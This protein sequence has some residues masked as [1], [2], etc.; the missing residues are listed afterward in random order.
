MTVTGDQVQR[1]LDRWQ[2]LLRLAD[3]DIRI[4]MGPPGWRKSGDVKIDLDDRKAVL[5]INKEPR[6]DNLDELVVHE[7][8]HIKL[9]ALDQMTEG[10]L[11][12]VY[13]KEQEDPRRSFAYGQFM[14]ALE[15]TV[16]DLTKGYLAVAGDAGP[17]SFGRLRRQ[18][19]DEIGRSMP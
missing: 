3:W 11:E 16:E 2:P 17:L 10:L 5:L 9:Y 14:L 7:L 18:V 8:L 4:E 15:S 13:G 6:T 19:E 12:A 1:C